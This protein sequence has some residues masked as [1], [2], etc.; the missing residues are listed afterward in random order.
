[1]LWHARL[2]TKHGG[3]SVC[4]QLG[5]LKFGEFGCSLAGRNSGHRLVKGCFFD[6]A[7]GLLVRRLAR[8]LEGSDQEEDDH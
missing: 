1:M 6:V 4:D 7:K 8:G 3:D 2:E 5:E